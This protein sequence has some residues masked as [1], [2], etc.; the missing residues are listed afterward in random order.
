MF[1]E[2]TKHTKIV[3]HFVR[4]K[5][6]SGDLTISYLPSKQ[7]PADIYTK[8]LGKKHFLYLKGKLGIIDPHA[9]T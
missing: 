6:E 1:H 9:L 2:K 8:A 3:R 7:Q 4:E 5:L